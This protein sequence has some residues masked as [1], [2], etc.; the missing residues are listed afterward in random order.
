M[1]TPSSLNA[2]RN[3]ANREARGFHRLLLAWF[4]ANYLTL[5]RDYPDVAKAWLI[6]QALDARLARKGDTEDFIPGEIVAGEET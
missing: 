3:A 2:G 4:A 5:A 6:A 1:T